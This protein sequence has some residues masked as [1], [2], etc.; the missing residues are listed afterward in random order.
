MLH[1]GYE[2]WIADSRE[3]RLPEYKVEVGEDDSVITCY[4]PSES[5]EQFSIRW[6]DHN[7]P[8][9]NHTNMKTSVDGV[10]VGGKHSR[11]GASGKCVGVRTDSESVYH[12]FQFAILQ[13]TDEEEA[14]WAGGASDQLGTIELRVVHV[15]ANVRSKNFKPDTFAGVSRVHERSKKAGAHC[16]ALG[17]ALPFNKHH[18]HHSVKTIPLDKRAP[19]FATFR[20][21]YRPAA[22]LQAQGIMPA[23]VLASADEQ[24]AH[25]GPNTQQ[26]KRKAHGSTVPAHASQA[27]ARVSPAAEKKPVKSELQDT[28]IH[29]GAGGDVIELSDDEEEVTQRRPAVKRDPDR[30]RLNYDPKRRDRPD[31]GLTTLLALGQRGDALTY[32]IVRLYCSLCFR[33]FRAAPTL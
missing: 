5:G 11:P 10:R 16:V 29:V 32:P 15:H 17:P 21:H 18:R 14:L 28:S 23:P 2:V 12:P 1:R 25:T 30:R 7:G 19:P 3:Q 33:C 26:K 22:I 8:M 13:T 6:K 4:I 31:A 20:F 27:I 24:D 9:A